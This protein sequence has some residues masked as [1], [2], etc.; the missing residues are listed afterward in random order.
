MGEQRGLTWA[1][2]ADDLTGAADAGIRFVEAGHPV[3][4]E[5]GNAPA[6]L[7]GTVI[8]AVVSN[9]RA[10]SD[11]DASQVTAEA[12]AAALHG[13]AE[14]IYLKIDSV[15]RGSVKAQISGAL[16]A[17][18]QRHPR[19]TALVCPAYPA[20]GRTVRD[21][22][23]MVNGVPATAT[24]AA[25]D[26]VT[27]LASADIRNDLAGLDDVIVED[28][29]DDEQLRALSARIIETVSILA[30]GSAGLLGEIAS[31]TAPCTRVVPAVQAATNV[32]V[33]SSSQHPA[34]EAQLEFLRRAPLQHI[35]VIGPPSLPQSAAE[36]VREFAASV[37][38]AVKDEAAPLI[39][40]G[41]DGALAALKALDAT[42]IDLDG[43]LLEG[44]PTG[45][46]CGG[47]ANG[48]RIVTKSGGFG[49]P[50]TVAELVDFLIGSR[51]AAP[52][53]ASS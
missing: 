28:A 1:V 40:I 31:A 49:T 13:G 46:V 29:I 9:A 53:H 47:I 12:V 37:V 2:I 34:A 8:H 5:L 44:C 3:H 43:S 7:P 33:A 30:V 10:L 42:H 22:V 20:L 17:W 4:V 32:I 14:R 21:G 45:V 19:G 52:V 41:G 16:Q 6:D 25:E 38:A 15:G 35:R 23:V 26:P 27:P 36:A 24:A 51:R 50:G 39:L 18:Q 48:L 11:H